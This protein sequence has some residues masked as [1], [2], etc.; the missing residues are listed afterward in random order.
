MLHTCGDEIKIQVPDRKCK[1]EVTA[2]L[3]NKGGNISL[4]GSF[5]SVE[6]PPKNYSISVS[7]DSKDLSLNNV[8]S[9][10]SDF[11]TVVRN[12]FGANKDKKDSPANKEGKE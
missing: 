4:G 3:T 12:G 6:K 10:D 9:G 2:V 8:R 1:T 7:L 11:N 5:D